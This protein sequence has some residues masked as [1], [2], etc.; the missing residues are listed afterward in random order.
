[1]SQTSNTSSFKLGETEVAKYAPVKGGSN[2]TTLLLWIPTLMP[3][4]PFALP[5]QIHGSLNSSC[6]INDKACK[7]SISKQ[8]CSQNFKSVARYTNDTFRYPYLYRGAVLHLYVR[9]GNPDT[10]YVTNK[11]DPSV[12]K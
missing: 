8:Y 6:F 12:K 10:M 1:M 4:I 5:R 2:D 3:N 11:I 7:P 9:N